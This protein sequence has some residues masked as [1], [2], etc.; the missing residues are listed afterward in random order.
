MLTVSEQLAICFPNTFSNIDLIV[1]DLQELISLGEVEVKIDYYYPSVYA[2][3][4]KKRVQYSLV[5]TTGLLPESYGLNTIRNILRNG[6]PYMAKR[7]AMELKEKQSTRDYRNKILFSLVDKG[8][9]ENQSWA[10]T[11]VFKRTLKGKEV[12]QVVLDM[13]LHA[14]KNEK[15]LTDPEGFIQFLKQFGGLSNLLNFIYI[16]KR[17]SWRPVFKK[18]KEIMEV[19]SSL[20]NDFSI[21]EFDLLT[22]ALVGDFSIQ[23]FS[24]DSS[25]IGFDFGKGDFS[26]GGSSGVW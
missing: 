19:N 8:Y 25:F 23:T 11:N 26:G 1:L 4:T 3:R 13:I 9:L 6:N 5:K 15:E 17:T 20:L 2:K 7:I 14:E 18:I 22:I 21:S 12:H 24:S 10:I 16:N